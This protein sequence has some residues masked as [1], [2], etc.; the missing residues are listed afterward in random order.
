[1]KILFEE[2]HWDNVYEEISINY[3]NKKSLKLGLDK[4][5][6]KIWNRWLTDLSQNS[7]VS[8]FKK[9]TKSLLGIAEDILEKIPLP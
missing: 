6:K 1:M 9:S 3:Y 7:K 5:N 2:L 4:F 8:D